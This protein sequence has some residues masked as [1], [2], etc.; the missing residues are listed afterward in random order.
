LVK[1]N[2]AALSDNLLESELFGHVKGAFT[3]AASDRSGRFQMAHRGTL[4]LDEIGDISQRMQLRLL[5]VLQEKQVEK[6]GDSKPI[7]VDVRV[8]ASTN[9]NLK[10][11]VASG[12]FREDLY[13]RLKVVEVVLPPL[14]ERRRDI[15]MLAGH[16][17]EKLNRKLKKAVKEISAE[18]EEL[19][20]AYPWPGNVR[21]LEHALEH[22]LILC[23]HDTILQDHLPPE[24]R[25]FTDSHCQEPSRMQCGKADTLRQALEKTAWNKAKAARLLGI[26]RKTLYR[27]MCRYGISLAP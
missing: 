18:V 12:D 4:L 3:G 27:K 8:I 24:L 21:E 26:D 1:V 13:Y 16:F 6:V 20:L 5:R 23:R 17:I 2:C 19:F 14:R 7:R 22:A 9:R 11:R 10:D 25:D 15:P